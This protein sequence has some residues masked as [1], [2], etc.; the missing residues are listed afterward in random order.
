[1]SHYQQTIREHLA[2]IGRLE[3]PTLD[4]LA[5]SAFR[6]EVHVATECIDAV[7]TEESE[8]LARSM[9]L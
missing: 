9:G 3:H 7:E 5:P 8:A 2:R 4:A 1:M 6:A